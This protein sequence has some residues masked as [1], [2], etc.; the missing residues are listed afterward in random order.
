MPMQMVI[1]D[2]P[3]QKM[4]SAGY[5]RRSVRE[6]HPLPRQAELPDRTEL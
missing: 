2:K 6:L 4:L 3:G 1:A 5:G